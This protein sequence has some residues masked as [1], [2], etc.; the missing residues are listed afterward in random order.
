MGIGWIVAAGFHGSAD[1][2]H[3]ERGRQWD[4]VVMF[5]YVGG[6]YCIGLVFRSGENLFRGCMESV[7]LSQSFVVSTCSMNSI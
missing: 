3:A 2:G 5:G 1:K 6:G 4:S 7:F